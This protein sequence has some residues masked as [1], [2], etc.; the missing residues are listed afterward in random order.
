MSKPARL[1]DVAE[2]AGVS[3]ATVSSYLNTPWLVGDR[4]KKKVEQAIGELRFVPN[5]AAR[6]LRSGSS[7]M[8]AFIAF[9]VSDPL[10]TSVARGARE[11]AAAVGLRLVLAD[12]DGQ[13]ETEQGYLTLFEEQ[14]VRGLLLAPAG[15]STGYLEELASWH[16]PTVL[17]DQPDP[18]LRWSS[19][20]VNDILGGELAV[21][22]LLELGRRRIVVVGGDDTIRQVADRREGARRAVAAVDGASVRFIDSQQRDVSAGRAAGVAAA[23]LDPLPDAIFCINDLLAAGAL[24][25]FE[26]EGLRVPDDVAVIGYN[27]I[28]ADAWSLSSLSSIRQPHEAF[29]TTA[30]ELLLEQL[31]GKPP[32]QVVF[33]PELIVRESTT[34]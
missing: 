11:S 26:R 29:G 19:V 34:G 16:M 28:A 15:D 5:A 2:H 14:R 1:R 17:I 3:I 8:V 4:S 7:R 18:T 13:P 24:Q 6:Q 31:D 33:D 30:M 27:D 32:R 22:H 23:R 20:S 10:F 21:S 12:T 25:S 9:D